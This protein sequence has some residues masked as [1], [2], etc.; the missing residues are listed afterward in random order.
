MLID[1]VLEKGIYEVL[2]SANVDNILLAS[3]VYFVRL[4]ADSFIKTQK[5]L[6]MK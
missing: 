5:I 6:L 2:F 1:D 3:G 4:Q